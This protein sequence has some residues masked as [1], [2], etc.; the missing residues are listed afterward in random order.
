MSEPDNAISTV[1]LNV[2][3]TGSFGTATITWTISPVSS[4]AGAS[5]LDIGS[6]A[7]QVVIPNGQNSNSFLFTVVADD[8]PEV[9]EQFL[10]TLI[11]VNEPNQMIRPQQV[12][13]AGYLEGPR[14]G[15]I[16]ACG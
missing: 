2:T 3:R 5:V 9:D 6:T 12:T 1:A 15:Y 14:Q 4:S 7:G 13:R 11:T 10:I 8:I 16:W